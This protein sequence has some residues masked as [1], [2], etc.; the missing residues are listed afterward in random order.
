MDEWSNNLYMILGFGVGK[1]EFQSNYWII[2][3]WLTE[4]F[5]LQLEK[6]NRYNGQKFFLKSI[7]HGMNSDMNFAG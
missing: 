6:I 5:F 3:P 7:V 2:D 4:F 1:G